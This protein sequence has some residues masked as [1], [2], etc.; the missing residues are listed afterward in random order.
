M[1]ASGGVIPALPSVLHTWI[2]HGTWRKVMLTACCTLHAT[3]KFSLSPCELVVRYERG[4]DLV[5]L[6]LS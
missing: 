3:L 6:V 1:H 4:L 2:K 5:G